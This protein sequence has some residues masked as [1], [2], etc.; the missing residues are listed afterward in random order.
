MA[1]EGLS[2]NVHGW[3]ATGFW[4]GDLVETDKVATGERKCGPPDQTLHM[5]FNKGH[6]D[7]LQGPAHQCPWLAR[8]HFG[9]RIRSK[10]IML[11]QLEQRTGPPI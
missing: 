3:G 8:Y 9:R 4:Q 6:P 2:T 10:P 1:H 11:L 7:G 5:V